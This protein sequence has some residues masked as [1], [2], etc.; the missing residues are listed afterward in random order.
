M[1]TCGMR[2]K[3]RRGHDKKYIAGRKGDAE[4]KTED[5]KQETGSRVQR[6]NH[7]CRSETAL[8]GV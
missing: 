4:Q 2:E 1:K 5:R 6:L 7:C 8:D 3:G